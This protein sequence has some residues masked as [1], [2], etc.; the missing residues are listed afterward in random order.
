M[1]TP[2]SPSW[3]AFDCETSGVDVFN[4]RI[5][6]ATVVKVEDGE[7]SDKRAW[8]IDPGIPIPAGATAVH[9]ITT[10]K[11]R[12]LGRDPKDA[13][14]EIAGTVTGILRARKPLVVF[15]AS[16]DLSLLQCETERHGYS[17]LELLHSEADLHTV[18]DPIVL[19]RGI[20]KNVT[21]SFRD[22]A[23]GKGWVYKL[24]ALCARFGVPFTES[25][26]AT[27][28]AFG[29]ALLALAL[30]ET[31]PQ[32]TT[33][34]PAHMYSLQRSW[35]RANQDSLRAYFDKQGTEHDGV[36]AGWPLHTGLIAKAVV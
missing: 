18:V 12:D 17:F 13:V 22:P 31:N 5:V 20:D 3:Y 25:H 15:N 19:A 36:D 7:I 9:G 14:S 34:T 2:W 11:A 24:P 32:I 29:A 1:S 10:E 8:L 4:D 33:Y 26:D 23:T 27:A 35:H 6:T 30:C 16:Y 21:R 28:D